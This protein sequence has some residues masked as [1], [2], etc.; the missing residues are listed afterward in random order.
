VRWRLVSAATQRPAEDGFVFIGATGKKAFVDATL[1]AGAAHAEY[2][3][4][5]QRGSRV[6]LESNIYVMHIG[7]LAPRMAEMSAA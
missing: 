3:V 5:G 6:G 4:Q 7:G 1:P 2:T